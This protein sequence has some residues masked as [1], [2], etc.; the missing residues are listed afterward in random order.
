MRNC[1]NCG[2]NITPYDI[3]L[4]PGFSKNAGPVVCKK[5]KKKLS[6][7]IGSY[8]GFTGL[9]LLVGAIA[10]QYSP[11][12]MGDSFLL[13]I[14]KIVIVISLFSLMFYLFV[15]LKVQPEENE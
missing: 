1:P 5:C 14:L 6:K 12:W 2:S 4:A 15:P 7:P 13:T 8:Q 10:S 9:G 11:S 3:I